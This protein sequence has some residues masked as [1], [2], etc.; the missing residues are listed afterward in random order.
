[1]AQGAVVSAA[2]ERT[3]S[4][5]GRGL[6]MAN[7]GVLV[8]ILLSAF[9]VIHATHTCRAFYAEL[10]KLEFHQ[11]HL[12]EDY[13]RL[14]LEQ[15]TWASHHRVENVARDELNMAPPQLTEFRVVTQ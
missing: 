1:M 5:A 14:L 8:L 10:Q 6:L 2:K 9:T 15:S 4:S 12:K 3:A 7:G 11:W 13:G